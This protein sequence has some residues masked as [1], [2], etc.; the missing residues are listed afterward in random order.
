[1][2]EEKNES[3]SFRGE[4]VN[5]ATMNVMIG[6]PFLPFVF[7]SC[8]LYFTFKYLEKRENGSLSKKK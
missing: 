4:V 7:F 8:N 6:F 2:K 5:A 3:T 1:M